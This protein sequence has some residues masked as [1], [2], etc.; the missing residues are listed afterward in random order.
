MSR[1]AVGRDAAALKTIWRSSGD[2]AVAERFGLDQGF[3]DYDDRLEK[4]ELNRSNTTNLQRHA[5][6]EA[7]TN[8]T[9]DFFYI[10]S[11]DLRAPL[12]NLEGFSLEL[13]QSVGSEQL[14]RELPPAGWHKRT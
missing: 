4:Q 8:E 7:K 9:A 12:I 10:L 6:L 5:Q 13:E 1:V 14:W 11:H 3:D 2:S